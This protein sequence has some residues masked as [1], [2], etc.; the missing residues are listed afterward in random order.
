MKPS[1]LQFFLQ[2]DRKVDCVPYSD[3]FLVNC[4]YTLGQPIDQEHIQQY[5][6]YMEGA[7]E[8]EQEDRQLL[9]H[10]VNDFCLVKKQRLN[11]NK[12][13]FFTGSCFHFYNHLSCHHAAV[14]QFAHMLP[15][16]AKKI[17][18]EKQ[19]RNKRRKTGL[20]TKKQMANAQNG[21]AT[22]P[23]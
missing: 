13:P 3:G 5:E 20:K 15:T 2:F 14:F 10:R 23:A 17:S 9:Y 11:P 1:L 18:Q 4:G 8:L 7:C 12:D 22:G 19:G 21:G 6:D 16:L